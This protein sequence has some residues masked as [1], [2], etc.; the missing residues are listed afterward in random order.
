MAC[1][2]LHQDSMRGRMPLDPALA[3]APTRRR[4]R[5]R[6]AGRYTGAG[7]EPGDHH[8]G[9]ERSET[10]GPTRK[11]STSRTTTRNG[12][13]QAAARRLSAQA[14][15]RARARLAVRASSPSFRR[16]TATIRGGL[17]RTRGCRASRASGCRRA[18]R[19]SRSLEVEQRLQDA[20]QRVGRWRRA[21]SPWQDEGCSSRAAGGPEGPRSDE[22]E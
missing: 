5:V 16:A 7:N 11:G 17:T 2:T 10:Q 13:R 9:E 14:N 20:D 15:T 4:S 6:P 22:C 3:R 8:C 21:I 12:Q 19:G 1:R 18:L